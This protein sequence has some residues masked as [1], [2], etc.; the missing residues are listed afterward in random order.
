MNKGE[1][2][3]LFAQ[4]KNVWN[5]WAEQKLAERKALEEDGFWDASGDGN[6]VTLRW[7]SDARA[8][9]TGHIFT[10]L[11]DFSGFVF[12]GEADFRPTEGEDGT[13]AGF[14]I[15]TRFEEVSLFEAVTFSGDAWFNAATF[16]AG[17]EFKNARFLG[18]TWF[19]DA[20]FLGGTFFF[21]EA[22]FSLDVSFD[23]AMFAGPALFAQ[24]TFLKTARFRQ[25]KFSMDAWF[26]AAT[27]GN[28]HFQGTTFSL[29]ARFDGAAFT[30]NAYFN[31]VT[32][33]RRADF[34]MSIFSRLASFNKVTF[35]GDGRFERATFSG[36]AMFDYATFMSLAQFDLALFE[37]F[38]T[39]ENARFKLVA[40]FVAV[41]GESFF[42][43]RNA[44]F[45]YAPNFE[46]AHFAE[47]PTFDA[48]HFPDEPA[49]GEAV[50][51]RALKRL[52]VQGQ[53]HERE[54]LFFAQEIKSLRGETDWLLPRPLNLLRG[55]PVWRGGA[56][57]WLGLF[58]EW[59]SDFGRS[60]ARPVV[61]WGVLTTAFALVYLDQHFQ[62]KNPP[63]ASRLMVWRANDYTP[64]LECVTGK[65]SAPLASA[66]YLAVSKG[67]V[68]GFGGSD[69]LAS[70][71][72]CLYGADVEMPSSQPRIPDNV[73]FAGIGQALLSAP[74]IFLFLLAV[75]NHFRIK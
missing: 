35:L 18:K 72:Y 7:I 64:P 5:A 39:F 29:E 9:F 44:T 17:A 67:L 56:R 49:P 68:A 59:S 70:A 43:L 30:G 58:Y 52:A 22:T 26:N 31:A 60:M 65:T 61:W 2:L 53:D 74:L 42:S 46:Q 15:R 75:R 10:E 57:Y 11:T 27:F 1:T 69:K 73:A 50:R 41:K 71:H 34:E 63:Y 16:S 33:S 13:G 32:F 6:S 23:G 36:N 28:A 62:F 14:N 4:G 51:W 21:S 40:G 8:D 55:R 25:T 45:Y 20:S 12:P 37:G 47:A 48:S 24:A 38:S 19:D 3:A 66:F 54:Q